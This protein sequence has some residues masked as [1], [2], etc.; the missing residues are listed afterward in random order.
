MSTRCPPAKWQIKCLEDC[1]DFLSP[2]DLSRLF[3]YSYETAV[4]RCR[5]GEYGAVK[6]GNTWKIPKVKIYEMFDMTYAEPKDPVTEITK[7][8]KNENPY[9]VDLI[10]S[11]V[12]SNLIQ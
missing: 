11:K 10:L 12:K 2:L 9:V 8:L 1:G 5:S 3:K 7:I 6:D 4:R